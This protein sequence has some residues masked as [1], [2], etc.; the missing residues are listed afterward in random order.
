MAFSKAF[1]RVLN[2]P[3]NKVTAPQKPVAS[4]KFFISQL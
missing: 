3:L 1:D 2:M 4:N